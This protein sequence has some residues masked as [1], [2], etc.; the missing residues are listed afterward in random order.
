M[1][2]TN[3]KAVGSVAQIKVLK[4]YAEMHGWNFIK[5]RDYDLFENDKGGQEYFMRL[6]INH[7]KCDMAINKRRHE[8][9]LYPLD[10]EYHKTRVY[11]YV[12]LKTFDL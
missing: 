10:N 7:G 2:L 12:R 8:M 11:D 1:A 5:T 3:I 4:L 6:Y 9:E